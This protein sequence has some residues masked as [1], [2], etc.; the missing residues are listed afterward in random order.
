MGST[1]QR[2][3]GSSQ[4]EPGSRR[5]PPSAASV[6]KSLWVLRIGVHCLLIHPEVIDSV[7]TYLPPPLGRRPWALRT[8]IWAARTAAW[9]PTDAIWAPADAI[10]AH[11]DA[12]RASADVI[13]APTD[14][15]GPMYDMSELPIENPGE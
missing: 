13:W 9:T 1:A 15:E 8:A 7:L 5:R 2:Q 11:A 14:A 6:S 12:I 4:G 10:C 3:Q